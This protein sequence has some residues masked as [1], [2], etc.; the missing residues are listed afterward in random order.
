MVTAL[1]VGRFQPPHRG[2][3]KAVEYIMNEMD[4]LAIIIGSAQESHSLDNPFTAGE[5]IVMMR[6]ALNE[7]EINPLKYYLIPVP[8]SPMH[9]T[10]VS[11]IMA[12]S[13]PFSIVYSNEPLTSRLFKE[14]CVT[15]KKIPLFQRKLYSSTEV[16]R[17]MLADENWRKLITTK[18]IHI[19]EDIGGVERLKEL[20]KIDFKKN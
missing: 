20:T 6:A 3:L 9:S 11:E 15:I 5:R 10:W 1:Y 14:S 2:H 13:P 17:R 4:E 16:R 19:I 8:D 12:Y 7:I 18:V